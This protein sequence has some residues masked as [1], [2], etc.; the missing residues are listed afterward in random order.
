M[1]RGLPES[2]GDCVMRLADLAVWACRCR[3][4]VPSA[5]DTPILDLP[6]T[7][8]QESRASRSATGL[9]VGPGRATLRDANVA[10]FSRQSPRPVCSPS[11]QSI[12]SGPHRWCFCGLRGNRLPGLRCA[13]PWAGRGPSRWDCLSGLPISP[14]P[15]LSILSSPHPPVNLSQIFTKPLSNGHR[16]RL[17]ISRSRK[18]PVVIG[19]LRWIFLLVLNLLEPIVTTY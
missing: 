10:G 17:Q 19:L 13:T 14:S 2:T 6:T 12:V 9:D 4:G 5:L 3:S 7:R 18:H 8:P 15:R 1:T 16:A 11:P